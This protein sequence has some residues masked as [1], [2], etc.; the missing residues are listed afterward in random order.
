MHIAD[1]VRFID[2]ADKSANNIF[3]SYSHKDHRSKHV[4]KHWEYSQECVDVI[5]EYKE[6]FPDVLEQIAKNLGKK[7]QSMTKLKDIFPGVPKEEAVE[8][9]KSICAWIEGLPLSKLPF[10]EMGFDALS[11]KL[12]KSIQSQ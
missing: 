4:R 5:N 2:S 10:V 3:D 8:S 7:S 12:I 6:K 9:I 11:S 1:Y